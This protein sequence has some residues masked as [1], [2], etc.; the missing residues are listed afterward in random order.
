MAEVA[1]VCCPA[2]PHIFTATHPCTVRTIRDRPD[3][4]LPPPSPFL[5]FPFFFLCFIIPLSC[6]CSFNL[7]VLNHTR[8][9]F[10][11]SAAWIP[12]TLWS[13]VAR[14]VALS[15]GVEGCRVTDVRECLKQNIM[16]E[17]VAGSSS[18]SR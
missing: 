16:L 8:T 6:L 15:G 14:R 1:Q 3:Y 7:S 10:A 17:K 11:P 13:H 5:F 4:F 2:F 9:A 12:R 18:S